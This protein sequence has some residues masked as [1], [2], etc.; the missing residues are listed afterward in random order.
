MHINEESAY[1]EIA[2][3][4]GVPQKHG[5][6]GR[7]VVTTFDNKVMPFIRY[8]TGDLGI[9]DA[10]PCPCDRTLNTISVR[11][12]VTQTIELPENR[13]VPLL[14]VSAAFDRFFRQVRQYQ[15]R[16]TGPLSFVVAIVPGSD[17]ESI[18]PILEGVLVRLMHPSVHIEWETA[19]HIPE[20]PGGKALYFS[21]TY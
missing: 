2:D 17:F 13:T 21:K 5:T 9:I 7:I 14:D 6:E 19:S 16:Q 4:Q 1:I 20:G 18:K 11:G 15:I 10:S 3:A 8:N 12:R